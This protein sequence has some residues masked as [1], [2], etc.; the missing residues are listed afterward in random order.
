GCTPRNSG[1]PIIGR[2]ASAGLGFLSSTA[3]L[4]VATSIGSRSQTITP[5]IP[6]PHLLTFTLASPACVSQ[7]PDGSPSGCASAATPNSDVTS[8]TRYA[9]LRTIGD[10]RKSRPA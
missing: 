10:P 3:G 9:N 6:L 8:T 5:Q 7:T 1:S 4:P 2:L